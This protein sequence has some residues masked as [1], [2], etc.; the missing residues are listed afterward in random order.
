MYVRF[1][2]VSILLLLNSIAF[3]ESYEC[4]VQKFDEN[5]KELS[6]EKKTLDFGNFRSSCEST[7]CKRQIHIYG[8]DEGEPYSISMIAHN[9]KP[10]TL[11][12]MLMSF[13]LDTKPSFEGSSIA[14]T[15]YGNRLYTQVNSGNL[16]IF[17]ECNFSKNTENL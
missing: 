1:I 16:N 8:G 4:V 17:I 3:A 2:T 13:R 15:D 6:S 14:G 9:A 5:Y 12:V 10:P 11:A 7:S